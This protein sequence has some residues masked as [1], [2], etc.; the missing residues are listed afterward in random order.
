MKRNNPMSNPS[1]KSKLIETLSRPEIKAKYCESLK[2]AQNR[3]EVKSKKSESLRRTMNDPKYRARRSKLQ[4]NIW[5][6]LEYRAKF[7][8]AN[9]SLWKGGLSLGPY[10]P[11]FNDSLRETVRNNYG[12]ICANCGKGELFNSCRLSVHHCDGD[13]MQGCHDSAWFGIGGRFFLVPLCR[14]CHMKRLEEDSYHVGLFWL[15]ELSRRYWERTATAKTIGAET[16][17][18][19]K[20]ELI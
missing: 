10:C 17:I 4:K 3:P 8:G 18:K 13:K 14:S 7:C 11:K 2:R 9:S 6:R 1:V 5:Q 19:S 15:T 12:M 16:T 20:G